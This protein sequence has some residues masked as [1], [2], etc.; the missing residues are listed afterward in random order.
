M[1]QLSTHVL[2]TANGRPAAGMRVHLYTCAGEARQLLKT[3]VTNTDGRTA[4]DAAQALKY[5]SV[6]QFLNDK[7]ARAS[8][9][10][11]PRE[12]PVD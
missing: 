8:G 4:L 7:G 3:A 1:A 9:K 11:A 5:Q 2:D 12:V 6:A 10:P